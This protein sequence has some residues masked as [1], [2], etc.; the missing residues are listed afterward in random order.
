MG[1]ARWWSTAAAG[2]DFPT[3][4]VPT[5]ESPGAS[6]PLLADG[7]ISLVGSGPVSESVDDVDPS[8]RRGRTGARGRPGRRDACARRDR[9][10]RGHRRPGL[11]GAA[12][13]PGDGDHRAL[14]VG[15]DHVLSVI[16]GISAADARQGRAACSTSYGCSPQTSAFADQQSVTANVDLFRALRSEPPQDDA[17]G[18]LLEL[19]LADLAERPGRCAVGW[20][21]STDG[22]RAGRSRSTPT[23][24]CS[25]SPRRS[26][27][28]LR[29]G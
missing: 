28:A 21:A 13:R 24:W 4:C 3:R 10:R 2:F 11:D 19:G 23:W 26:S 29:H 1:A 25:T 7:H 20:R 22:C 5:P 8:V 14:R 18:V 15:Q 6:S 16:L 12:T 17:A 9:P 27:T